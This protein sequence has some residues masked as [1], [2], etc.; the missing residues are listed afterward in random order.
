MVSSSAHVAG[1]RPFYARHADAYDLLITDPVGPWVTLVDDV[2]KAL[3][4]PE[5]EVLDAGCGTGR[6][7]VGLIECGH[8]LTLLDASP[9]LLAIAARRCPQARIL[10]ADLCE[11]STTRCFDAVVSRGV[12]N[13]LVSDGERMQGLGSFARLTRAGGVLVLDV[14]EFEA[15]RPRADGRWRTRHVELPDGSR[16]RFDSRPCWDDG[17]IMVSERYELVAS[18]GART[19]SEYEFAMRP[20]R[21]QEITTGLHATG[22]TDIRCRDGVGRRTA[23]RLVVTARRYASHHTRENPP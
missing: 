23:D 10:A 22:F 2:L 9:D 20:W 17:R 14:R 19:V 11:P 12:L 3:G 16:L 21:V 13:D 8:R 6:H 1:E 7:A 5:A 4:L 15:S 18:D